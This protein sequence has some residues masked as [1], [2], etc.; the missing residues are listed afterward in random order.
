MCPTKELQRFMSN[1]V[2][3]QAMSPQYTLPQQLRFEPR[4]EYAQLTLPANAGSG[5]DPSAPAARSPFSI[6]ECNCRDF[7]ERRIE[8]TFASTLRALLARGSFS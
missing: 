2:I 4:A 1:I 6:A 5:R 8:P 7:P 3:E